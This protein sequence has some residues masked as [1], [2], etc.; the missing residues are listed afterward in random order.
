MYTYQL[1]ITSEPMG[2]HGYHHV[3]PELRIATL[4]ELK[5][6]FV[7]DFGEVPNWL[8]N[9]P[10]EQYIGVEHEGDY[11]GRGWLAEVEGSE[12]HVLPSLEEMVQWEKER[13][14]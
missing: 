13:L 14:S 4:V 1:M 5:A 9:C 12:P 7:L 3:G 6:R 2:S 8:V 11:N 10:A